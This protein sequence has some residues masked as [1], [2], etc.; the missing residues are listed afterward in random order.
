[1]DTPLLA[2]SFTGAISTQT[3]TLMLKIQHK[4]VKQYRNFKAVGF[5]ECETNTQ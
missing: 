2:K 3:H 1:M 4:T 5:M